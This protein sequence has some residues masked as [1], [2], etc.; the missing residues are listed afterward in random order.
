MG[1]MTGMVG[2]AGKEEDENES[3]TFFFNLACS[4][5]FEKD[6]YDPSTFFHLGQL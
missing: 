1:V 4:R 6:E 3:S 2:V 5:V